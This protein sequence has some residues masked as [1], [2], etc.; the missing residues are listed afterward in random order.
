[1]TDT[2][3]PDVTTTMSVVASQP[4]PFRTPYDVAAAQFIAA[5]DAAIA[6]IPFFVR[7]HPENEKFVQRYLSFSDNLIPNAIAAA[8]ACPEL[9]AMKKFNV[10][11]ARA[12][13][14]FDTAFR[15]VIDAVDQLS[16]NLKFTRQAVRAEAI[17][18]SLQLYAIAKGIGR[19]PS[20]A[21]V[22]A[23][24]EIMK[25]SLK[26]PPRKKQTK[27]TNTPVPDPTKRS[28]TK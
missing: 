9:A 22:A 2:P 14:Q 20:S 17:A 26:T 10:P 23:H 12:A 19:D 3:V 25:R 1:M 18:D 27:A 15:T 5:L 6:L 7:R 24:A 28:D 16:T 13:C 4:P 8:E 11:K 21:D